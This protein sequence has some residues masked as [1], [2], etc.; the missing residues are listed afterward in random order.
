MGYINIFVSS[1]A[2]IFVKNNQLTL[3]NAVQSV[4]YPLE[5]VNSIM[6]ENLQ[7][8]IST[9]T[10]SK[11]SENGILAFICGQNHLPCG[12]ILPF[13]NHYNYNEYF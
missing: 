2:S 7:T 8:N 4:D 12:V 13:F 11:F 1:D 5:D 9:Y 6:I 10:L 3:K